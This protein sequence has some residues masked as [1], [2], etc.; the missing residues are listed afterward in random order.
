MTTSQSNSR[1]NTFVCTSN[2]SAEEK[3]FAVVSLFAFEN[4]G[5]EMKIA[6]R[7]RDA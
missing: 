1:E 4:V 5:A 2:C 7:C 3:L 6:T